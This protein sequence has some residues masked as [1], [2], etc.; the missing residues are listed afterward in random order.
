[1]EALLVHR[2]AMFGHTVQKDSKNYSIELVLGITYKEYFSAYVYMV[3]LA[4]T[5]NSQ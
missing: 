3:R 1:M 4:E 5:I 2:I